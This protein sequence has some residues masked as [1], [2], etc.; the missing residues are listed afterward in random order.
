MGQ[1][2]QRRFRFGVI[3][4]SIRSV[5]DLLTRARRAEELGY[6]TLLL[7]DHLQPEPF[8]DQ[9]APLAALLAA[10]GVTSTL[11]IG[12]LVLG[13]DF[14][15][16]VVLAKEAAT[17]DLLSGRRFELGI[18]AGWSREEY[19][20]AGLPFSPAAVRVGRLEES[21]QIL[22]RL[23]AGELVTFAGEHYSVSELQNF[24]RPADGVGPP[25]LIGAGSK[26]MLR[27]A[28]RLADIVGI[29]PRALPGGTISAEVSERSPGAMAEK[30][31]WLREAAGQRFDQVELSIVATVVPAEDHV[32]A[33]ERLAEEQGWPGLPAE[34]VLEMPSVLI[35]SAD[36]I[37]DQLHERRERYGLSYFVVSD[38]DMTAMAP[39]VQ[40]LSTG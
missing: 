31:G 15:H 28:G 20:R 40:F 37:A 30:I 10:A 9:L 14:R 1:G 19:D 8:G 36:R 33:A 17:V 25:I 39:T 12:T 26:R 3:G 24:P 11:R 21:V 4:E 22:R 16:P 34:R 29:L 27:I 32:A 35:G 7:R 18:G 13:N 5:E 38:Q 6:S 2:G 23:L